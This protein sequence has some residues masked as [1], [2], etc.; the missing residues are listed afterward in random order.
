MKNR[1]RGQPTL[2]R[3]TR[4][5][6]HA[7]VTQVRA[8][9]TLQG[10]TQCREGRAFVAPAWEGPCPQVPRGGRGQPEVAQLLLPIPR[11][12]PDPACVL[13]GRGQPVGPWLSGD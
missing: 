4:H 5:A 8:A 7:A 2:A 12:A 13:W 1:M 11:L 3:H 6:G 9:K 10:A